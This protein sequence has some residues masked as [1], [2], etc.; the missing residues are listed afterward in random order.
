MGFPEDYDPRDDDMLLLN[1]ELINVDKQCEMSV[2]KLQYIHHTYKNVYVAMQKQRKC[3]DEAVQCLMY[4]REFNHYLC[5]LVE[6]LA[7]DSEKNRYKRWNDIQDEALIEMVCQ[8]DNIYTISTTLGRS[9]SA[10]KTRLSKLVGI[11]RIS[12][13][14]AGTFIGTLNGTN[15][16]GNIKG[17]LNKQ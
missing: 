5:E 16:E 13:E 3:A 7:S 1:R 4:Y 9:P 2:Y 6:R 17:T 12:E 15:V 8:G 10:I 14:I 11:S